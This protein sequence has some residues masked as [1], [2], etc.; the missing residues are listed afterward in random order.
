[1]EPFDQRSV[2]FPQS[3]TVD[4]IR[5]TGDLFKG[6]RDRQGLAGLLSPKAMQ[7]RRTH[8]QNEMGQMAAAHYTAQPFTHLIAETRGNRQADY[9][10]Y[11]IGHSWA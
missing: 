6:A 9:F 1:M 11:R 5:Q 8:G 4:Q 3:A 10:L 7:N 2:F